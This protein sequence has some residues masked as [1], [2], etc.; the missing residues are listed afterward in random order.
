MPGLPKVPAA[1]KIGE[2]EDDLRTV[3][4]QKFSRVQRIASDPFPTHTEKVRREAAGLF[5]YSET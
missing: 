3:L 5:Q 1:E 4:I 2:D